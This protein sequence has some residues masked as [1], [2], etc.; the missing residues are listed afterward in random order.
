MTGDI[1]PQV[2]RRLADMHAVYRMYDHAG[3]LLYVGMSGRAGRRFDGHSDRRWFPLVNTIT[4]E[5]H[6]NHAQARIA[7]VRAIADEKPRY[8]V[9][10]SSVALREHKPRKKAAEPQ[11]PNTGT[12]VDVLA[13]F[14][15]DRGLHWQVVTDRLAEKFPRRWGD[16]TREAIRAQ[17]VALGVPSVTVRG[18]K[19]TLRGC[20][21]SDVEQALAQRVL[22]QAS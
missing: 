4:L 20:R 22:D 17:C 16:M 9:A 8:N 7:E 5:W 14:G 2:V 1:D 11:V 21:R 15:D 10:G 13:I 3:R 18:K 12:L 19:G 6:A